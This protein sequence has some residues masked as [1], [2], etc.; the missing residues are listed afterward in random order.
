MAQQNSLKIFSRKNYCT[1]GAFECK[2]PPKS[3]KMYIFNGKMRTLIVL[4][5]VD[6]VNMDCLDTTGSEGWIKFTLSVPRNY[7]LHCNHFFRIKILKKQAIIHFLL[8]D[9]NP[10]IDSEGLMMKFQIHIK[11]KSQMD[12]QNALKIFSRKNF[13][14]CGAFECKKHPKSGKM[15]IFNGKMRTLIVL[16]RVDIV[17]MDCLDTTGSEGWIKF[18][19]SAPRKH[20]LHCNHFIRI[21]Y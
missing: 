10:I 16:L 21:K 13:C 3:G 7:L 14:T 18:T 5:R 6:I 2:K 19:L 11:L 8:K 12:Q 15:Y 1:C 17:N 9:F 4:L 20:L